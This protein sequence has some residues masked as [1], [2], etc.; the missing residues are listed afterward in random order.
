MF[1]YHSTFVQDFFDET[2]VRYLQDRISQEFEYSYNQKV[3]LP[4]EFLIPVMKAVIEHRPD[5]I[6]Q[7]GQ[8]NNGLETLNEAVVHAVYADISSEFE[9]EARNRHWDPRRENHPNHTGI[10]P[11]SQIKTN[12]RKL[13]PSFRMTY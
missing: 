13:N 5:R 2:N 10:L 8:R 1:S 12:L 9:Q 11:H 4:D 6:D 3:H 7:N